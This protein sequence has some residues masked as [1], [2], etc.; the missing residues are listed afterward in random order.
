MPNRMLGPYFRLGHAYKGILAIFSGNAKAGVESLRE[1]VKHLHAMHY[2][3]RTTE[4]NIAL[5][6]GLVA[7]ARVDEGIAL[8]GETIR[9]IEENG[10][11]YFL[12]EALRRPTNCN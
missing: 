1:S 12:P 4:L 7:I 2:E 10:E 5:T 6:L 11:F 8:I 9:R 3:M